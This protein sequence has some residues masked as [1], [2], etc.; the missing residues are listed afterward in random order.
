MF[1]LNC[2]NFFTNLKFAAGC[3]NSCGW[4]SP[5]CDWWYMWKLAQYR[6]TVWW[7]CGSVGSW[8]FQVKSCKSGII[9]MLSLFSHYY[10]F[11]IVSL[12]SIV[13]RMF[14]F[15]PKNHKNLHIRCCMKF[16]WKQVSFR[17]ILFFMKMVSFP[18]LVMIKSYLALS[19]LIVL[20]F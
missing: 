11:Q 7:R 8:G 4:N 14:F 1:Q 10:C 9:N 13:L 20:S 5:W 3:W 16:R 2:A 19:D 15:P 17:V 18:T 12:M 6:R